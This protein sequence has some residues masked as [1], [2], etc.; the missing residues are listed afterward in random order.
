[1]QSITNRRSPHQAHARG[2]VDDTSRVFNKNFWKDYIDL[3]TSNNVA[4][5]NGHA[6]SSTANMVEQV[7]AWLRIVALGQVAPSCELSFRCR[8]SLDIESTIDLSKTLLPLPLPL[9]M[10]SQMVL[11]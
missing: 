9:P 2:C 7:N 1:M 5:Y 11:K 10:L 6:F 4:N 3:A 8:L